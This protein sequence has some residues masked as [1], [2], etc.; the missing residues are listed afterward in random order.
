MN[1]DFNIFSKAYQDCLAEEQLLLESHGFAVNTLDKSIVAKESWV[2]FELMYEYIG[3][4]KSYTSVEHMV[5]DSEL[6][7]FV[8]A[9]PLPNISKFEIE[10]CVLITTFKNKAGLKMTGTAG[11]KVCFN[12][13]YVSKAFKKFNIKALKYS[14]VEVSG[15]AEN[16]LIKNVMQWIILFRR[17]LLKKFIRI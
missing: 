4:F 1:S 11:N 10:K 14:W 2:L 7:Q 5:E 9:G 17:K 8:Y 12:K 13:M 6:I 15:A 16:T 3:G